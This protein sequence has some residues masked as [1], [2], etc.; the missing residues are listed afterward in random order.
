MADK[1]RARQGSV[2][3]NLTPL[4]A[5]RK[6]AQPLHAVLTGRATLQAPGANITSPSGLIG[7]F[8]LPGGCAN[9]PNARGYSLPVWVNDRQ[10]ERAV[11]PV[12]TDPR[13]QPNAA[14]YS[15]N[16]QS[17]IVDTLG[18]ALAQSFHDAG[19]GPLPEA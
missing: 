5:K 19:Y 3:G 16:N 7:I 15:T 4:E 10:W 18:N 2:G 8:P 12:L 6:L 1:R 13:W 17:L 9:T 14:I 11:V